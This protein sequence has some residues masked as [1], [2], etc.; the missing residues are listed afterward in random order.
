MDLLEMSENKI[1]VGGLDYNS[2]EQAVSQHFSQWGPVQCTIKRFP[3]G[4]Y[5]FRF[6]PARLY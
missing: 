2:G 3:D 1:F 6:H 4:R 5:W